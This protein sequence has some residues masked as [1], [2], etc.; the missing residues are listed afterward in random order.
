L[1]KAD[2]PPGGEGKIEVSFNSSHKKGQQTQAITVTSND[3]V[4]PTPRIFITAFIEVEFDFS[5]YQLDFGKVAKEE[6]VTKSAYLHIKD[7]QNTKITDIT[8]SSPF[9]LAKQLKP[10]GTVDSG[11]I[12]V[13]VTLS[14]GLPPGRIYE[15]VTAHSNL[16]SM[17]QAILRVEGTI[18]GDVDVNPEALSF[19]ISESA[20]GSS[21]SNQQRLSI[22]ARSS[23]K[24]LKI[25]SVHDS[26]DR[27][28]LDLNTINEGRQFE[29]VASLKP[30]VLNTAEKSLH[31][32]ILITTDNP[33]QQEI[34]VH[35]SIIKR[36]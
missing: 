28:Q 31:G 25:L 10:S 8:T 24:P 5:S 19:I 33:D 26:D 6:T 35:Y 32:L 3:P 27:L 18:I 22:R 23:A 7:P 14:P 30:E 9:I 36:K 15:T 4:N 16:S 13:E 2:I 34:T 29:I 17:P 1:T 12:E 21:Q 11:D 20:D